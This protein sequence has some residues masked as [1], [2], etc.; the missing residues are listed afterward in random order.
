MNKLERISHQP[1]SGAEQSTPF[2]SPEL[3]AEVKKLLKT[4]TEERKAGRSIGPHETAEGSPAEKRANAVLEQ[5]QQSKENAES[6]LEA[7]AKEKGVWERVKKGY[8]WLGKQNVY[9]AIGE[10]N[11]KKVDQAI[12]SLG[13][14]ARAKKLGKAVL[15]AMSVRTAIGAAL[16]YSG[17][18]A[19]AAL[20]QVSAAALVGMRGVGGAVIG[21]TLAE[22]FGAKK[23]G[24]LFGAFTGG[25]VG[26]L[27]SGGIGVAN[28]SVME[29]ALEEAFS[30][31]TN[32]EVAEQVVPATG[33][34]EVPTTATPENPHDGVEATNLSSTEQAVP[35]TAEI[36]ST[37]RAVM[38]GAE[39]SYQLDTEELD[40]T[41]DTTATLETVPPPYAIA[42]GD[43]MWG[44]LGEKLALTDSQKATFLQK[45]TGL[46][47]VERVAMVKEFGIE[48]GNIDLIRPG[49]AVNLQKIQS[50]LSGSE[51]TIAVADSSSVEQVVPATGHTEVPTTATPEN[52][53]DGVEATNLS[54]T[55]QA[56]PT[57]E[58]TTT[59]IS[60]PMHPEEHVGSGPVIHSD[61]LNEG[62]TSAP[63]TIPSTDIAAMSGAE[64]SYQLDPDE[65]DTTPDTTATLETASKTYAIQRGDTMQGIL[66]EKL[67]LNDSQKAVFLQK[68]T[69]LPE[70]QR[71]ATVK[72]FGI[73]S[74][75]LDLIRP[76]ETVNLE[77]IQ[78]FLSGGEQIASSGSNQ[79]AGA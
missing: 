71:I 61:A 1:K 19:P 11:R 28:S 78:N 63:Q 68:I 60:S 35:A 72:D 36:A 62:D 26:V 22:K 6:K 70:A 64:T 5:L 79:I 44:V 21:D 73:G 45:L 59:G 46:P 24:R 32:G 17:A 43:T 7:T 23:K 12:E 76:G 20:S 42:D 48:S 53:H 14:G 74:G 15:E 52:P 31:T 13:G 55:E 47:E 2:P 38:S 18:A 33:H 29:E 9:R 41:P 51:A 69:G 34:T 30:E 49:E 56:V 25:V 50:F 67:A 37:D 66:G 65:L 77:K 27:L 4:V 54:S 75:N 40:T 57:T 8:T 3:P 10:N 16:L 39:T 58:Q